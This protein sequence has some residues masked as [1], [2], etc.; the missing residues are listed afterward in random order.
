M[1][2]SIDSPVS[3]IATPGATIRSTYVK[4]E[5]TVYGI[6]EYEAN[7]LSYLNTQSTLFF[8][9]G[10]AFLGYAVAIWT[11]AAFTAQRP[12]SGQAALDYVAPILCIAT[13][14]F[15]FAGIISTIKSISTWRR[16]KRQS[17]PIS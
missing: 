12:L 16:I 17:R 7:T 10:T 13:G 11:N 4:R 2:T 14:C 5:V 1:A 15:Y 3:A 8:S 9:T 6:H